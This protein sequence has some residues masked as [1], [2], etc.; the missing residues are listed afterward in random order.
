MRRPLQLVLS[1]LLTAGLLAVFLR[2][3]DEGLGAVLKRLAERLAAAHPGWIL[4]SSALGLLIYLLR[5]L[6]WR[7]LLAPIQVAKFGHVISATIIGFTVNN[8]L[9]ARLGE[10]VR[11]YLLAEK[12]RISKSASFATIVVERVFDLAAVLLMFSLYLVFFLDPERVWAGTEQLPLYRASALATS[13]GLI[14]LVALL[15]CLSLRTEA[16]LRLS[17]RAL[18]WLPQRPR[19][20]VL[21]LLR[22]F[23]AGLAVLRRG[24]ALGWVAF[25]TVLVWANI[26]LVLFSVMAAF[27]LS[28]SVP[29]TAFLVSLTAVGAATP[30]PGGLGGFQLA[31]ELGL[32][33]FAGA[34]VDVAKAAA[35]AV[36]G[37]SFVPVS[38]LGIGFL[39][40]EGLSLRRIEAIGAAEAREV[41]R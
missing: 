16:T 37:V 36:W 26:S 20:A 18:G 40:R 7:H 13:A 10:L 14:A 30:T 5:A 23:A 41:E 34:E 3:G 29:L 1:L 21:G 25:Y 6:R 28:A 17:G 15:Y 22:Q 33:G 11:A 12:E 27:D 19:G 4:L 31:V 38:I 8:F 9:P 24:H 32:I 35:V 2:P 39:I